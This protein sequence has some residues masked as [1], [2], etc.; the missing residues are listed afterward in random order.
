MEILPRQ[1]VGTVTAAMV[2]VCSIVCACGSAAHAFSQVGEGVQ[3]VQPVQSHSHC[4]H[5]DESNREH[6]DGDHSTSE[7]C[8]HHSGESSCHQCQSVVGVE[9]SGKILADLAPHALVFGMLPLVQTAQHLNPALI[10]RPLTHTDLPPPS[11]TLLSLHCA[12]TI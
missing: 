7:P 12:L 10:L 9:N 5:Q 2:L 4:D 11:P 8:R 1:I 3:P 6:Q